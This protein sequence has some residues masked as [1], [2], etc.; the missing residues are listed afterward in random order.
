MKID[1]N[2][3]MKKNYKLTKKMKKLTTKQLMRNGLGKEVKCGEIRDI[4][5][6]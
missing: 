3:K 4:F 2:I 6:D 1:Q 5:V